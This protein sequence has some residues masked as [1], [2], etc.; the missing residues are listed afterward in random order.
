M[1][2][3]AFSQFF[4]G[5][6]PSFHGIGGKFPYNKQLARQTPQYLKSSQDV[7]P[8][9]LSEENSQRHILSSHLVPTGKACAYQPTRMERQN[10]A[11]L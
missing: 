8:L 1:I 10:K 11:W 7:L 2:Y 9:W 6:H 5:Y 4:S 3:Q